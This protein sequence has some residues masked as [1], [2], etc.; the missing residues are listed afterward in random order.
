MNYF[1]KV[2]KNQ[3]YLFYICTTSILV[4]S[5]LLKDTLSSLAYPIF[6]AW[7][8]LTLGMPSTYDLVRCLGGVYRKL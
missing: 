6:F 7:F 2:F 3:T 8:F 4:I 5:L 1:N